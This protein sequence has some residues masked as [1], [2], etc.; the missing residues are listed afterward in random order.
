M[1]Y[2]TLGQVAKD[3]RGAAVACWLTDE[4]ALFQQPVSLANPDGPWQMVTRDEGFVT[5][6]A[7]GGCNAVAAGGH[8]W[9]R[10]LDGHTPL[11][12]GS[13]SWTPSN[14][15]V[16]D[17][18][19]L[20][21]AV[22]LSEDMLTLY[23]DS[24][25]WDDELVFTR[26]S[27]FGD[28][29]LINGMV[30][31]T[32]FPGPKGAYYDTFSERLMPLDLLG[33][34]QYS[35]MVFV[36]DGTEWVLYQTDAL[37][38]LCHK[39]NDKTQGYRWGTPQSIY[40]P[41]VLVN[42]DESAR[43]G[44][45][46]DPGEFIQ[47]EQR[48]SVLGKGM[49]PLPQDAPPIPPPPTP[50]PPTPVPPTPVPP[51]ES[52]KIPADVMAEIHTFNSASPVPQAP[53][54]EITDGVASEEWVDKALRK[55]W[56]LRLVEHLCFKFGPTWGNKGTSPEYASKEAIA[57]KRVDGKMDVWDMLKGAATGR[58]RLST[59]P[60]YYLVDAYW[61]P[62]TP[63]NH[64]SDVVDRSHAPLSRQLRGIT[65]FDLMCRFAEDDFRYWDQVVKPSGLTP[66]IVVSS[67]WE[68]GVTGRTKRT[69]AE[70]RAQ[71][72]KTLDILKAANRKGYFI[73]LV[74]TKEAG[75]SRA[76]ALEE[77]RLCNAEFMRV[78]EAVEAINLG[79]ENSHGVEMSY[80]V[81]GAFYA[82]AKKLIDPQ[83]PFAPG[84]GHGGEGVMVGGSFA[85]HHANRILTPDENGQIMAYAQTR[86]GLKVV[87]REPLGVTE[88]DRVGSR[89]RTSL[90]AYARQLVEACLKYLLG[91]TVLHTD[92]GIGCRIEQ[93][94][95]VHRAAV[96]EFTDAFGQTPVVDTTLGHE[97]A[98][99][100][101]TLSFLR[102]LNRRP[103]PTGLALYTEQLL[104]GTM[105]I[106]DVDADIKKSEE[107][108]LR[109]TS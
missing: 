95:P 33:P 71:I 92:S 40:N 23:V 61:I 18:D 78:P 69:P 101:V 6:I 58:P 16:G 90:A 53:D 37:G 55:G 62:V 93:H 4:I 19:R 50:V 81:D 29:R 64:L 44:W 59:D 85:A 38:G 107:Y 52:M 94:G 45:S 35:V 12:S 25:S 21:V 43:I 77:V 60:T 74:D 8:R 102:L 108:R 106:A 49:G 24:P 48:I 87:D 88:E 63:V 91:G 54:S 79:N 104:N 75:L 20:G 72:A 26:P 30:A 17:V 99:S 76:D 34:A 83:F 66:V 9:M 51:E 32:Q 100:A 10:R 82:E 105:T 98:E 57:R 73:L 42:D 11:L 47:G 41:D 103:D 68:G 80:M 97:A 2:N 84:A 89:Q 13:Q 31:W 109:H 15:R 96:L 28:T 14:G 1:R 7:S 39:I 27:V 5:P 67:V 70:G 3:F 56:K 65:A 46:M 22:T 36:G 86:F